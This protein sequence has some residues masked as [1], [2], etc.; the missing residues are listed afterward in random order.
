MYS[1]SLIRLLR[2]NIFI[3]SDIQTLFKQQF[4]S[5]AHLTEPLFI[6]CPTFFPPDPPL[7]HLE[8]FILTARTG[9]CCCERTTFPRGLGPTPGWT[10]S[11]G[12]APLNL[13]FCVLAAS[14]Q[15]VLKFEETGPRREGH[16]RG[17]DP[18]GEGGTRTFNQLDKQKCVR[19]CVR[20]DLGADT[21][22]VRAS[23]SPQKV[24]MT[25]MKLG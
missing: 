12:K 5:T 25:V 4:C 1:I 23:S 3:I 2:T 8:A 10:Q 18:G 15:T 17:E 6:S 24:T 20:A 19:A 11:D 14:D 16:L 9:C 22:K 7:K 21:M 13:L